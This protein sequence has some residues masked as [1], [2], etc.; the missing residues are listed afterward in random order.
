MKLPVETMIMKSMMM[1]Q[2]HR[3]RMNCRVCTKFRQEMSNRI[4]NH[5]PLGQRTQTWQAFQQHLE[6]VEARKP[7]PVPKSPLR[8]SDDQIE[9]DTALL[10]AEYQKNEKQRRWN[11]NLHRHGAFHGPW[12][13]REQKIAADTAYYHEL[14]RNSFLYGGE[15]HG[16]WPGEAQR[17]I[18]DYTSEEIGM[19]IEE[20]T[21]KKLALRGIPTGAKASDLSHHLKN[22]DNMSRNIKLSGVRKN[23]DGSL[24]LEFEGVENDPS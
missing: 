10:R 22:I 11:E 7:I 19:Y 13:S 17:I 21:V 9:T 23:P 14:T 8:L 5:Y 18:E 15:Y 12:Q 16:P 6:R 24:D 1:E 4:R 2:K 3:C 20:G